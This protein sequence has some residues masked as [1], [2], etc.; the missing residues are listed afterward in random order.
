MDR[1]KMGQSIEKDETSME[2]LPSP[3]GVHHWTPDMRRANLR[4]F[5]DTRWQVPYD[6]GTLFYS[7]AECWR[8][9]VD[10]H[11]HILGIE[12][13]PGIVKTRMNSDGWRSDISLRGAFY[14]VAAGSTIEVCKENPIDFILATIDPR[15]AERLYE[16]A[17]VPRAVS[18]I[19]HNLVD[20]TVDLLSKQIRQRFLQDDDDIA[21][22]ASAF[23]LKAIARLHNADPASSR[24]RR[25]RLTSHQ[26]KATLEFINENLGTPL[27]VEA[28]AR[29]IT[30]LSG[31]FFAHAFSEALGHSP[32]Q[33][34]L[35]RRV[36]RACELI[37]NTDRP[38]ADIA[39][40]VGFS[41]QAH[42]T[43]T[44]CKRLGITPRVLRRG[45]TRE[46]MPSPRWR[47][48][49]RHHRS[50]TGILRAGAMQ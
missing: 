25:Y 5:I 9:H 29:E 31:Y 21:L 39:Y 40:S 48:A 18:P 33:Y 41:S 38:L 37:A 13:T 4:H 47:S 16:D 17:G 24:A 46:D 1:L 45:R 2:S 20:S 6:Y 42:M 19:S 14:F 10:L 12:M 44:I 28:L 3:L 15:Q 27:S 34:I 43:S 8:D 30:G 35:A 11:H 49:T 23:V 50:G 26:I 22:H 32:H 36:S 7:P